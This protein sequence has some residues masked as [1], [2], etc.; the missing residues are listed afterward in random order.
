MLIDDLG[1][2]QQSRD[3][4]EVLFTLLDPLTTAAAVDRLMNNSAI[5][6]M[7]LPSYRMESAQEET[8][9]NSQLGATPE[10]VNGLRC[11][12]MNSANY[13]TVRF[14]VDC[15]PRCGLKS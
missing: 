15:L 11:A 4:K 7:N 8:N 12:P 2:V 6:E 9:S 1:Y 3:E 13:K 14:A 5:L 10:A